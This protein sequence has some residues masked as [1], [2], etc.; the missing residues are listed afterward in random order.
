MLQYA[1]TN[2]KWH[3][4][5]YSLAIMPLQQCDGLF[6]GDRLRVH[7]KTDNIFGVRAHSGGR[8]GWFSG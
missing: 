3:G 6:A 5:Q 1:A 4:P 7:Q 8:S 2:R